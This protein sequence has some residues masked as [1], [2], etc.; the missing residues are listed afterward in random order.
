MNLCGNVDFCSQECGL[1]LGGF[2][3]T[4]VAQTHSSACRLLNPVYQEVLMRFALAL[5]VGNG[6]AP[7]ISGWTVCRGILESTEGKNTREAER[8]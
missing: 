1:S 4:I 7:I 2:F 8:W 3:R 6:E 5:V